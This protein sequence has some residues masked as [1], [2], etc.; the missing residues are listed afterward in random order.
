[1]LTI[2]N[3]NFSYGDSS[4]YVLKNIN[5][6]IDKGVYLSIL[7]ENGSGKSTLLKLLLGFLNPSGGS[8]AIDTKNIGYVPQKFESYNSQ[9]PITVYEMMNVHRKCTK[10]KDKSAIK[11]ALDTVNM[12]G[13]A[14]SLIGNLSGGQRQ[15]IF[16][17][18]ALLGKPDLL[19]LDEPSTGIDNPSQREIYSLL[20]DLNRKEGMTIISVEHNF[21][22]AMNNSS[23]IFYLNS[24]IG[25]LHDPQDFSATAE[26]RA[27]NNVS[28]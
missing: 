28:V 18:R 19:V 8:I 7:G 11:N 24:G 4:D 5:L 25:C 21:N 10:I 3:L 6:K 1:M 23:K 17:A 14:N 16:I 22:A 9:F 12:T 13:F 15:K 20:K 2:K 26:R 27:S